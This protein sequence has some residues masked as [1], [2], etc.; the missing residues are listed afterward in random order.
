MVAPVPRIV[1]MGGGGFSDEP[2]NPLLDDYVVS[3]AGRSRPRVCFLP[4]AAGDDLGYVA[5]FFDAFARRAEATWLPLFARRHAD[6][7]GLLLDQDVIYVGGGNTANMLAIWRAHGVDAVLRDAWRAGIVLAGLSAG[8]IC[9]FRDGVTDSFGSRARCARRLL[10][11]L[12]GSFCPHYDGEA[13]RRPRYRE[14]VAAGLPAA[15]AATTAPRWCSRARRSARSWARVRGPQ[16]TGSTSSTGRSARSPCLPGSSEPVTEVRRSGASPRRPRSRSGGRRPRPRRVAAAPPPSPR[17]RPSPAAPA[18]GARSASGAST[19]SRCCA[20]TCG[21]TSGS[22][23]LAGIVAPTRRRPLHVDPV[24]PE[25]QQVQ[26]HLARPPSLPLLPPERPLQPL[27]RDE[28]RRGAGRRVRPRRHVQRDDR[29]AELRL[30]GDAHR[31][32]G[33]EPRHAPQPGARAGPP[34]RAPRRP[35]SPPGRPRSPRARCT[36]APAPRPAASRSLDSGACR[37]SPS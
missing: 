6:V 10:A 16:P 32:R 19:N 7:R 13:L 27:E 18:A 24:S 17:S 1:A 14:L 4:T 11:L 8:A 37:P 36:P 29:V 12:D 22:E 30:V 9:W 20:S 26:V 3:L 31:L 2:D 15:G 28:Q 34:G 23:A 21:T 33:V 35:A 5:G 25:D